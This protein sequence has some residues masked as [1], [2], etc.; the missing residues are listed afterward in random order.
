MNAAET[1]EM[2]KVL[3]AVGATHFKSHDFE[4]K[5]G[6]SDPSAIRAH[7]G[8]AQQEI[9]HA[10]AADPIPENTE[11]TEKLKDLIKTMNLSPEGLVDVIFPAGAGL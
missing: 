11:A 8:L 4:I 2:I 3:H 6:V 10:P 7:V 9:R 1:L 5:L